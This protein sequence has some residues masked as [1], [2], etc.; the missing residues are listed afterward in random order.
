MD[1]LAMP[2]QDV[3]AIATPMMDNLM[4]AS[5][6]IDHQAHTQDFSN[7]LKSLVTPDYL[8]QVC[9]SYQSEKGFFADRKFVAVFK[10]QGS[11]VI[12]W[13]QTY[14]KAPGDYLAE[15]LLLEEHGRVVCDHVQV[16]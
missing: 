3:L 1:F 15:M 7:R 12:I 10:R 5:T 11:A 14:T 2:D 6:R 16:L 4:A 13:R 9:E 8:Q